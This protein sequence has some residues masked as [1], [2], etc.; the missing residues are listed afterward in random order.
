MFLENRMILVCQ[1]LSMTPQEMK[2]Y[3]NIMMNNGMKLQQ[4]NNWF[5]CS[6]R[7]QALIGSN[8]KP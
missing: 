3:R 8:Q 1:Q 5:A 2:N 7:V 4:Y 6:P